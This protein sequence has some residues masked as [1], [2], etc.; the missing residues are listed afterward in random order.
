ML[1]LGH[2]WERA[3]PRKRCVRQYM[4]RLAHRYRR[5]ASSHIRPHAHV[6]TWST[7]G[8][9]LLAKAV[10]QAV[11]GSSGPPLSQASQL[12]HS[13]ACSCWNSAYC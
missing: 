9:G 2:L 1:E 6:G 7:V 11:H 3:C 10:Y 8:A 4:T 12:P 13:T 5:Q